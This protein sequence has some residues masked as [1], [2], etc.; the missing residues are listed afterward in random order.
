MMSAA[1]ALFN[2]T[3]F[4]FDRMTLFFLLAAAAC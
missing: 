2:P 3:R 1:N 4:L